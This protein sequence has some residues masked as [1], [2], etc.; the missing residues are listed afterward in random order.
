MPI[1]CQ[2]RQLRTQ[3]T[4]SGTFKMSA[5]S[6]PAIMLSCDG[7][8]E[9]ISPSLQNCIRFSSSGKYFS[10][11]C[12]FGSVSISLLEG[13]KSLKHDVLTRYSPVYDHEFKKP[14][15]R[16]LSLVSFTLLFLV[17]FL[18]CF[19]CAKSFVSLTNFHLKISSYM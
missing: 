9:A 18:F 6:G 5:D 12:D 17:N 14:V 13:K 19:L 11:L 10:I 15:K 3:I 1:W 7:S 4:E 8:F 16:F 2:S